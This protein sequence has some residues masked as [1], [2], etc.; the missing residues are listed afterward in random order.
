M[1]APRR[2][3]VTVVLADAIDVSR[4]DIISSTDKPPQRADAFAAHLVWMS[5]TP[6]LPGRIFA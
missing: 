6:L 5:E 3:A 2:D 4:G 1:T